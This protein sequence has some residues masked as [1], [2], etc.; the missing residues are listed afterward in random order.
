MDIWQQARRA[1]ERKD[2]VTARSL[3]FDSCQRCGEWFQLAGEEWRD[4]VGC[5]RHCQACAGGL[6]WEWCID[7]GHYYCQICASDPAFSCP[8]CQT[9]V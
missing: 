9:G 3:G 6:E 5:G 7:C 8:V 2:L 4:C 1:V